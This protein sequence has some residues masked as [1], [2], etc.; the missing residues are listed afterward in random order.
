[1]R[2]AGCPARRHRG[3]WRRR[4]RRAGDDGRFR[5]FEFGPHRAQDAQKEQVQHDQ[6]AYLENVEELFGHSGRLEC[7]LR[8]AAECDDI[9]VG[10]L[11]LG[12]PHTVD[13]RAVGRTEIAEHEPCALG[14]N[15]CVLTAHIGVRE[16]DRALGEPADREHE[17]TEHDALS[18]RQHER[19][20][21]ARAF[22]FGQATADPELARVQQ[23]VGLDVEGD[24]PEEAVALVTGVSRAALDNSRMSDSRMPAICSW[25]SGDRRTANALGATGRPLTPIERRSSISR[26]SRRPISTGRTPDLNTRAKVPSTICSRR[27]SIARSPTQAHV[28]GAGYLPIPPQPPFSPGVSHGVEPVARR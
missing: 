14:T 21:G 25:S 10:Q 13:E 4:R 7:D 9:A 5:F 12:D 17:L 23:L 22:S 19:A 8:R 28:S 6:E 18:R 1:M 2:R 3:R 20:D 27:R 16:R 15:L 24:R 11:V 26:T